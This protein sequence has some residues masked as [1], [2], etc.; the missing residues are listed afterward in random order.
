VQPPMLH[1][2][3][4]CQR[5]LRMHAFLLIITIASQK[6]NACSTRQLS[7]R[8]AVNLPIVEEQHQDINP[9]IFSQ[10]LLSIHRQYSLALSISNMYSPTMHV[11]LCL[12]SITSVLSQCNEADHHPKNGGYFFVGVAGESDTTDLDS[13]HG[14]KLPDATW[15]AGYY[16]FGESKM[17]T[18]PYCEDKCKTAPGCPVFLSSH[19]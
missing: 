18:G 13:A 15:A 1:F 10:F 7:R 6:N 4:V 2:D 17:C 19:T 11:L 5:C 8:D 16:P 9:H 12:L 3:A 14:E